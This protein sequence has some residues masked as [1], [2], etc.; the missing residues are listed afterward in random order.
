MLLTELPDSRSTEEACNVQASLALDW[1]IPSGTVERNDAGKEATVAPVG[2]ASAL[3]AKAS[4]TNMTSSSAARVLGRCH[5]WRAG[6]GKP[7][8]DWICNLAC[9]WLAED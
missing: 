5:R 7:S 2:T 9:L 6:G 1:L 8:E 3:F 4:N